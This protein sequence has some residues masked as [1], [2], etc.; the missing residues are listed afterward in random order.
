MK[1]KICYI[2]VVSAL[3]SAF[4]A[5]AADD[6]R[7]ES[8]N[9]VSQF[10]K[11]DPNM[12]TFFDK[13][14]GYAVFPN[15]AKGGLIVGAARGKGMVYQKN[16][17]VGQATMT[18]ASFGAQAGGQTFAE[19]IFFETPTAL[20]DFK[21]GNFEMGADVSAVAAAEGAS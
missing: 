11:T 13:A 14:A 1:N 6:V 18:Q 20:N 12:K 10:K 19:I 3:L 4:V 8:E 5:R 17:L 21:S 15:V 9:V 7:S 2:A 16:Q